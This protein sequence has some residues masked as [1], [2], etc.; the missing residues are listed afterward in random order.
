MWQKSFQRNSIYDITF[1]LFLNFS[2]LLLLILLFF[3]L[4]SA[5][6]FS[7]AYQPHRF[8][9]GGCSQDKYQPNSPFESSLTSFLSSV[10]SSSSQSSYNSFSIGNNTSSTSS[11]STIFGLYQCRGDLQL[12][13]CSKCI[14]SC[15][16]QIGLICPHAYGASL[17]LE[18]CYIRYQSL[19]ILIFNQ[20]ALTLILLSYKWE[21]QLLTSYIIS[22]S[23]HVTKLQSLAGMS[24]W[25]FQGS[26]ITT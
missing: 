26:Q 25:I 10:S 4:S 18:G 16:N 23:F 22:E 17:Q 8:I 13:D 5:I 7:F 15:V 20:H 24:I 19:F 3:I 12:K 11:D 2:S 14:S 6:P 21:I 1:I 9:Y